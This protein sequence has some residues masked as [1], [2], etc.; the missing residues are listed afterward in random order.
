[1]HVRR[2][3]LALLYSMGD[4]SERTAALDAYRRV[5]K[6][7]NDRSAALQNCA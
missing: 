2:A 3:A 5:V 1:M 7:H 6:E 4:D